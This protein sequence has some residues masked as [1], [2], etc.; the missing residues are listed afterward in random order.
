[1]IM[2]YMVCI[3]PLLYL[4]WSIID[5]LKN[6]DGSPSI[7]SIIALLSIV[8]VLVLANL[9]YYKLGPNTPDIKPK[10]EQIQEPLYRRLE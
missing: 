5:D 2:F 1:M 4:V 10:Y 3:L 6:N 8:C 7:M 9:A